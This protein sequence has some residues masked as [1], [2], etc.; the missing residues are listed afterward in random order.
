MQT[1]QDWPLVILETLKIVLGRETYQVAK[2]LPVTDR[3]DPDS[4][5]QALTQHFELQRN[6]IFERYLFNSANQENEDIYQ[7]LN[8]LRKLASTCAYGALCDE[9][10]RDRLVIGMKSHEVR[11]RLLREKALTL[12]TALDINNTEER[13]QILQNE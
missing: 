11:T 9:L 4:F 8:R 12:K 6:I 3:T 7:Y 1:Y 2:N 10:I 13:N 5:L